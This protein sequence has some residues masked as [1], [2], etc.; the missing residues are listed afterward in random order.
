MAIKYDEEI[1]FI[2]TNTEFTSEL[3]QNFQSV[4]KKGCFEI[5][6]FCANYLLSTKFINRPDVSTIANEYYR[7]LINARKKF[8]I[9]Y[10]EQFKL[11]GIINNRVKLYL[12]EIKL[13]EQN[14]MP[15]ITYNLFFENPLSLAPT[16]TEDL[17]S[18]LK[19]M[20][21]L[22]NAIRRLKLSF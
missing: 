22:N 19:F 4:S 11:A 3:I 7:S 1:Y 5:D 20:P 6:I 10:F 9:S 16:F 21:V 14:Q 12:E 17:P 8:G 2:I 13:L 18:L 15:G